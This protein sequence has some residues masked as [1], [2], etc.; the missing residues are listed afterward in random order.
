MWGK[1]HRM[2]DGGSDLVQWVG[3]G[4]ARE[5]MVGGRR[6]SR[7]SVVVG[8]GVSGAKGGRHRSVAVRGPRRRWLGAS[9][10]SEL[11]PWVGVVGAFGGGSS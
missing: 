11:V 4:W 1:K 5:M 3:V 8:W 10:D 6:R 9:P 2:V 7:R